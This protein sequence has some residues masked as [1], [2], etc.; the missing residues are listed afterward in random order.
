MTAARNPIRWV[1]ILAVAA[2]WASAAA[3]GAGH[4]QGGPPPAAGGGSRSAGAGPDPAREH[5]LVALLRFASEGTLVIDGGR[6]E[7]ATPWPRFLA[8]GMWLRVDGEWDGD[9]F[10]ASALVVTRPALF[11]YY[12]GPAGA[13]DLGDGWIEAW[14]AAP[15]AGQAVSV[16]EVRRVA[17]GAE[18]LALVRASNGSWLA[19]APGLRPPPP[20]L[21]DGWM[22]IRGRVDDGAVRWTASA[23]FP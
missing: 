23:P 14:F 12:R 17:P 7:A 4:G 21:T 16:F 1:V 13:L 2:L 22:L 19:L 8:P 9:V 3:Q 5:V 6:V 15:G 20:P 18:T 11:S 10:V